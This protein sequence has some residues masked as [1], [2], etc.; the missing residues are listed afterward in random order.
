MAEHQRDA[1]LFVPVR[2]A[3]APPYPSWAPGGD[4]VLAEVWEKRV[5]ALFPRHMTAL[6]FWVLA[7]VREA[8]AGPCRILFLSRR[9]TTADAMAVAARDLAE[10][11]GTRPAAMFRSGSFKDIGPSS[12]VVAR[13]HDALHGCR[14]TGVTAVAS[15]CRP[16]L[17]EEEVALL[18]RRLK[19][20]GNL[21]SVRSCILECEIEE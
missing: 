15:L 20:D 5:H 13:L 21:V 16:K 17:T 1:P 3:A 6:T 12:H 9:K 14:I 19:N 10:E 4:A 2:D 8:G 7:Q 18:A 11:F